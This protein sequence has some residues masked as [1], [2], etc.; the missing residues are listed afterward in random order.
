MLTKGLYRLFL[1]N[2]FNYGF[3]EDICFLVSKQNAKFVSA[4]V[5]VKI[6][7]M[8]H[9]MFWTIELTDMHVGIKKTNYKTVKDKHTKHFKFHYVNCNHRSFTKMK[10]FFLYLLVANLY[11][12]FTGSDKFFYFLSSV[13]IEPIYNW[14]QIDIVF[15]GSD[16]FFYF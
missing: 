7:H 15:T 16:S 3:Y 2:S 11:I 9:A 5:P 13:L 8:T 1:L 6:L 12:V 4:V 14:S 10:I